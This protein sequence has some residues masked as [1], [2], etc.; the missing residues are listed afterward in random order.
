MCG[1][2]WRARFS[3][4]YE[5]DAAWPGCGAA[6]AGISGAGG[7]LARWEARGVRWPAPGRGWGC[8]VG[9]PACGDRAGVASRQHAHGRPWRGA[10][11]GARAFSRRTAGDDASTDRTRTRLRT[12]RRGVWSI[13]LRPYRHRHPTGYLR[14]YA[15]DSLSWPSHLQTVR[16]CELQGQGL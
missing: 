10:S 7:G 12:G 2:V 14:V 8:A 6:A 9:G 4:R 3:S 15:A 16:E 1:R 11:R 5:H 13:P